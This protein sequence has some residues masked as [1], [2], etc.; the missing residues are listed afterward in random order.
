MRAIKFI[1]STLIL[2]G[3]ANVNATPN[4]SRVTI[5]DDEEYVHDN[6]PEVYIS[7]QEIKDDI[8]QLT[9]TVKKKTFDQRYFD[10][11]FHSETD[12]TEGDTYMKPYVKAVK[13]LFD[14]PG[15]SHAITAYSVGASPAGAY[16][17]GKWSAV[18]EYFDS[19]EL[20]ACTV[21]IWN[22]SEVKGE[23]I[24]NRKFVTYKVNNKPTIFMAHGNPEDGYYYNLSWADN[25]FNSELI[26]ANKKHDPKA[27]DKMIAAAKKIDK[28]IKLPVGLRGK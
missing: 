24:F 5:L 15:V 19:P 20:G 1:L 17:N 7:Q 11:S 22:M 21:K 28:L 18:A 2:T 12:N 16:V 10:K 13:F 9:D 3:C 26:C 14:F 8:A 4:Y 27:E 6:G 23:I 25:D